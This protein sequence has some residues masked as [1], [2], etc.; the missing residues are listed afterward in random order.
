M[1]YEYRCKACK[2]EWELTQSIKDDAATECP[3]CKLGEAQRLI[4][5]KTAFVLSGGGWARDGYSHG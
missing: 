5:N 4:S 1:I 3:C 2:H